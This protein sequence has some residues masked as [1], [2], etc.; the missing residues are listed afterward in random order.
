MQGSDGSFCPTITLTEALRREMEYR[1]RLEN[2]HPHLLLALNGA[3]E[4]QKFEEVA[5]AIP[6]VSKRKLAPESTVSAQQSN[7]SCA[8]TLRQLQNWYPTKKKVKV[9]QSPSQ[10]LQCPRPNVVPSFWCKICKV[11]CVTEFNFSGHIGGKKHK[12]KKLEIL[13]NRNT[14]RPTSQCAGN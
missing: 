5:T 9:P 1:K 2:T 7:F 4:M 11:D 6:D 10:I 14:G 12:A 13:G 8:T 3:S